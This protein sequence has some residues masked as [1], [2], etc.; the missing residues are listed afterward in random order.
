MV[1]LGPARRVVSGGTNEAANQASRP[2]TENRNTSGADGRQ[3]GRSPAATQCGTE[4]RRR[5]SL[6]TD[7]EIEAR[8]QHGADGLPSGRCESE[9]RHPGQ[10]RPSKCWVMRPVDR[11]LLTRRGGH[12]GAGDGR[13]TFVHRRWAWDVCRALFGMSTRRSAVIV[14]KRLRARGGGGWGSRRSAGSPS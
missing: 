8:I 13:A 1:G 14:E 11:G 12:E 7:S 9:N 10:K 4:V 2:P 6:T 3:K 5:Y